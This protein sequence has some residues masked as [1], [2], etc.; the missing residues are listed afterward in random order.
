MAS[1]DFQ[2]LPHLHGSAETP[3]RR[4]DSTGNLD[5]RGHTESVSVDN[6]SEGRPRVKHRF[7]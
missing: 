7:P 6:G 4:R 5:D 1:A 3:G 2:F